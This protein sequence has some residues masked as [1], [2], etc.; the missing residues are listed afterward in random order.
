MVLQ[1]VAHRPTT[2][3]RRQLRRSAARS[4]GLTSAGVAPAASAA[5]TQPQ[6]SPHG[7][8]GRLPAQPAPEMAQAA[9]QSGGRHRSADF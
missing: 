4:A 3:E 8:Q 6:G 9:A 5:P 2:T 7:L 1:L